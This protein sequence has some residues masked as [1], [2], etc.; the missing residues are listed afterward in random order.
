MTDTWPEPKIW[1]IQPKLRD[2]IKKI[3]TEYIERMLYVPKPVRA[4]SRFGYEHAVQAQTERALMK[5]GLWKPQHKNPRNLWLLNEVWVP[6]RRAGRLGKSGNNYLR[7]FLPDRW[8]RVFFSYS[9][10]HRP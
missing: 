6:A 8:W 2:K 7:A 4:Q 9:G 1:V 10:M 5:S 3:G